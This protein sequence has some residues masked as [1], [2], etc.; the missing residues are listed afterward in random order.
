MEKGALHDFTLTARD[1]LTKEAMEVL[2]GI[3]GLHPDST[4]E[5]IDHLPV[6]V[7]DSEARITRQRLEAFLNDEIKAG[8]D[9]RDAFNKLIKEIAFTW[10]NRLIAFK[11]M[12]NQEL[13]R[14]TI[15]KGIDSDGFKRWITQDNNAN[16]LKLYNQGDSPINAFGEG[17]RDVAYRHFILWQCL[18]IAKEIKV[19]FDIDNIPSRIFPRP[20][21]LKIFIQMIDAPELLKSWEVGNEETVGWVYQYFNEKEKSDVWKSVV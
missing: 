18:E 1:L 3:Y 20:R 4:F 9:G 19:L 2:E 17:P 7:S 14:Q 12:E 10:L 6:L 11:M 15:S 13:I 16:E 21:I 8:L 5:S